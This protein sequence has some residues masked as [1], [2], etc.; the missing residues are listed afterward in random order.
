MEGTNDHHKSAREILVDGR[1]IDTISA[2]TRQAALVIPL[3]TPEERVL[4]R[5][6]FMVY[7]TL[8]NISC[9]ATRAAERPLG[10]QTR[11]SMNCRILT[12]MMPL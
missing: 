7:E 3:H 5:L 12:S 8:L 9:G 2:W 1:T 4:P 10:L 6:F 11:F